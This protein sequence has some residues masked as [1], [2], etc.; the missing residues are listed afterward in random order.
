MEKIFGA[1]ASPNEKPS[2]DKDF[3]AKQ[4]IKK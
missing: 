4:N 3:V 2:T 1:I